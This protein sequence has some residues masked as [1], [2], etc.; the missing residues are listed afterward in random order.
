MGNTLPDAATLKEEV[1]PEVLPDVSGVAAFDIGALKHVET[2]EKSVLPTADVIAEESIG[3]RAEV[4][5]FDSSKLKHVETA[6]KNTLPDAATLK[7]EVRPEVLLD[8]SG[9]AA[10]DIGALKH[11][12]TQEK[13]VLPTADV[14]AEE[15]IGT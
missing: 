5:S 8:V 2:K 12:Q 10:F 9:V 14:I 11:V 13:S 1:R 4:L 3:T 6:E 7:E 15:S